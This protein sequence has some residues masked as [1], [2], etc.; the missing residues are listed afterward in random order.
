MMAWIM[1]MIMI[2]IMM[3]VTVSRGRGGPGREPASDG[4][5]DRD[6]HG[7]S[8]LSPTTPSRSQAETQNLNAPGERILE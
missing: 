2:M 1:I 5:C 3:P 4:H 7:R 6:G 8:G